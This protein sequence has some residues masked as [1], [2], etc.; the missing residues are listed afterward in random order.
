MLFKITDYVSV[1]AVAVS[2]ASVLFQDLIFGLRKGRVFVPA[3]D[4]LAAS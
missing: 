3:R 1:C 4:C 2:D